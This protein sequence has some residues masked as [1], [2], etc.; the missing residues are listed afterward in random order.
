MQGKG[1]LLGVHTKTSF[2]QWF[3]THLWGS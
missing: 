2:R 3:A 1:T